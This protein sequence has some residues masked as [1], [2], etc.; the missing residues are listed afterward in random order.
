MIGMT[1]EKSRKETKIKRDG[2]QIRQSSTEKGKKE[3]I[4]PQWKSN[5]RGKKRAYRCGLPISSRLQ[6]FCICKKAGSY[7]LKG[8]DWGGRCPQLVV[9]YQ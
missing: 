2:I 5:I 8:G 3:S 1:K 9:S 6:R 4:R 7:C